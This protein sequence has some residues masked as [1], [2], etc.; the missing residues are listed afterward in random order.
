MALES[1]GELVS[2][3][4]SVSFF[5]F[6]FWLAEDSP[7]SSSSSVMVGGRWWAV[8]GGQGMWPW[9]PL[10]S[11][12]VFTLCFPWAFLYYDCWNTT[13][14]GTSN[15]RTCLLQI[16]ESAVWVLSLWG[17]AKELTGLRPLGDAMV[18]LTPSG[19][20]LSLWALLPSSQC[21]AVVSAVSVSVPFL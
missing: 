1:F 18:I 13:N 14:V 5:C 19:L 16:L 8:I 3:W 15:N 9:V 17:K 4:I 21:V 11:G 2:S 6:W 20:F 10:C 7:K 12:L